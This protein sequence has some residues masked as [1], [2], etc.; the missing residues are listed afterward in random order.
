[1]WLSVTSNLDN[2]ICATV[3]DCSIAPRYSQI[4]MERW[5]K[6]HI[7]KE[8]CKHYTLATWFAWKVDLCFNFLN[9]VSR[10]LKQWHKFFRPD[11]GVIADKAVVNYLKTMRMSQDRHTRTGQTIERLLTYKMTPAS[12]GVVSTPL[13]SNLISLAPP[14]LKP[15][16]RV[17][18]KSSWIGGLVGRVWGLV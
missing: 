6:S 18:N 11:I 5:H 9:C 13:P 4:R 14:G 12:G 10:Q 3:L 17:R 1:M 2:L 15:N 7:V 16:G 8:L